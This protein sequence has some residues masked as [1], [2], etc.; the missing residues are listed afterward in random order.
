M[1]RAGQL[2]EVGGPIVCGR[3]GWW[4]PGGAARES[5]LFSPGSGR[6]QSEECSPRR[7]IGRDKDGRWQ[8]PVTAQPCSAADKDPRTQPSSKP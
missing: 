2:G 3:R 6:G 4:E 5:V 1:G 7:K 8:L